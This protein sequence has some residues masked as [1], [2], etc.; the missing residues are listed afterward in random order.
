MTA[1]LLNVIFTAAFSQAF[2]IPLEQLLTPSGAVS[3]VTTTNC[4]ASKT[5]ESCSTSES[6]ESS[7]NLKV[8]NGSREAT[9]SHASHVLPTGQ[10][11]VASLIDA[12]AANY[13]AAYRLVTLAMIGRKKNVSQNLSIL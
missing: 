9:Y 3:S 11:M 13:H 2:E 8:C 7:S 1:I 4:T 6:D 12:F 10:C 5:G